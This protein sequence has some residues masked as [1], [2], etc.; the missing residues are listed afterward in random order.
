M[1]ASTN[2]ISHICPQCRKHTDHKPCRGDI[3]G[4]GC[5]L[6]CTVCNGVTKTLTLQEMMARLTQILP[7]SEPPLEVTDIDTTHMRVF[8]KHHLG[9][10]EIPQDAIREHI[11]ITGTAPEVGKK[12]MALPK[13][14][15]HKAFAIPISEVVRITYKE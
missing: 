1:S 7:S 6:V 4:N 9:D 13:G 15:A 11:R 10:A 8:V 12:I 5:S 14:L 3:H 2:T